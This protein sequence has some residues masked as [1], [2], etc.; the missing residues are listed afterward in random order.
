MNEINFTGIK[1]IGA[2]NVLSYKLDVDSL[3][4]EGKYIV[5]NLTNDYDGRDL[6]EFKNAKKACGSIL[7]GFIFPHD[8]NFVHISSKRKF[9]SENP[10][11]YLNM[12][13]IPVRRETMPMF[14]YIA[15]LLRKI[16]GIESSKMYTA[17]DFKYGEEGDLYILGDDRISK[18]TTTPE[19]YFTAIENAFFPENVKI[20]AKN[21]NSDLQKQM[22]AY[23]A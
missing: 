8:P 17:S 6:D 20:T 14:S 22:E 12:R 19:E 2:L 1:N 23:F 10:K 5:A 4:T 7:D 18:S 13:E 3:P 11:L 16:S 21:I 15:K 9:G